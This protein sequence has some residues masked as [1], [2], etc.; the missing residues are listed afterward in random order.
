MNQ[1]GVTRH[2]EFVLRRLGDDFFQFV[3][4]LWKAVPLWLLALA[5]AAIVARLVYRSSTKATRKPGQPDPTGT[6]LWW[7]AFGSTVTLVVWFLAAYFRR[8]NTQSSTAGESAATGTQAN[9]I[10]WIVFTC[11]AFVLG[12]V[13]AILMYIRD[14]RSIR[15]PVAAALAALRVLVYA[16]LCT[17]FLLPAVQTWERVEKKSR[18]VIL[19]DVSPSMTTISDEVG[20]TASRKPKF[21][22]THVLDFLTDDK[23][24]FIQK[25]TAKNPVVVYRF[26]NRLDEDAQHFGRDESGFSRAEWEAFAA[27]D[28]KPFLLRALSPE[29]REA[30]ANSAAWEGARPGTAA[31]AESWL[32]RPEEEV[33]P[34]GIPEADAAALKADRTKLAARVNTA[35]T[36][37]QG[38]NVVD[39]VTAAVNREATNMVQG[40]IVISDGRSNLGSDSGFAELKERATREKIPIFTVAVGEDR[41]AAAIAITDLQ[42]PDSTPPDEGFKVVVEADGVNLAGQEVEVMLDL[43]LPGKNPKEDRP[44]FTLD[45]RRRDK[46]QGTREPYMLTFAPGDPPHGQVEFVVDPALLPSELTVEAT[47]AGTVK[48][49]LK[50]GS[51]SAVARIKR[52]EK[53]AF[54]EAEHTLERPRIQVI[55]KPLRVLLIASGPSREYQALRTLLVREMQENRVELCILLQNEGGLLGNIVQDVPASRLL[56]RWPTKLDTSV[57]RKEAKDAKEQEEIDKERFYNLNEYDLIIAFDPDLSELTKQQ[58]EDLKLWVQEQGGGLIF[59]ADQVNTYQLARVEANSRL[60]PILDIL[61]VVPADSHVLRGRPIPR[62]PRR[63]YL[64]PIPGSDLLKLDEEVANDPVAGWERFFT[65]RPKYAPVTDLSRELFPHRGFMRCYPVKEDGV[66]AG[67]AVLAE[68]ADRGEFT[69]DSPSRRPWLVT[70][71]P[72]A[73]WRTCYM[74]SGEMHKTIGYDKELFNRFWV[75]LAKYMAAKRNVKA[76]RGRV[77]LGEEY[78]SGGPIRVQARVLNQS[79]KPYPATGPGS[80]DPKFR[81]VQLAPNGDEKHIGIYP[82]TPKQG[83]NEFDGYY[84][85]QLLAD[86]AKFPPGDADKRYRYRVVIDVPDSAGETIEGEF[87]IRLSDPE[88][89]NTRPDLV[90]MRAMAG[91]VTADFAARLTNAEVRDKLLAGLP[92]ESGV[93]KLAFRLGDAGLV[94]LIPE[95]M[96]TEEKESQNRGPVNDLWDKGFTLPA[97]MTSWAAS[98]PVTISYVLLLVVGLLCVEWLGRKLQRLA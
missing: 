82:M 68:F 69:P 72:A 98:T 3:G 18:V 74:A 52:N 40:V 79:S 91:D 1:P 29:G 58:A 28:F 95:C 16:I 26:S 83:P 31:W 61:P 55:K 70:N 35:K 88:K 15:W 17:V 41:Q 14:C 44:D 38:T 92:A 64:H 71:N 49:V 96:K 24:A 89:D 43:F 5:L 62:T 39:S 86:P 27:Y 94:A 4:D 77:L 85:G 13:F 90:A 73:G 53:E 66:K 21:R 11:A 2:D 22:M 42:A 84:Q 93:Q 75:K 50:E 65:D 78:V 10:L 59:V 25:L 80:V 57:K 36:I 34:A 8:D 20:P 76:A 19:L 33:I 60:S 51:W 32:A 56:V 30:L 63:L 9:A 47:D 46:M 87:K 48:R 67:A 37:L 6:A 23:V 7:S 45:D 54:P 97:W 81:I 12:T